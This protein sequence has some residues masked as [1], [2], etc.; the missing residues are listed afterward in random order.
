M[1]RKPQ[2]HIDGSVQGPMREAI[3]RVAASNWADNISMPMPK[4]YEEREELI[5]QIVTVYRCH[6]NNHKLGNDGC[7]CDMIGQEVEISGIY[8]TPFVG[9][10]S[11]HIKG[12]SKRIQ[13]REFVSVEQKYE[14]GELERV[15]RVLGHDYVE[16]TE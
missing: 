16:P 9:T 12:S 13:E 15:K 10:P 7:L 8:E 2:I 6:G 14:N 5:G 4:R 11:Y 3:E 1:A